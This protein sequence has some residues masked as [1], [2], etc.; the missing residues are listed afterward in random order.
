MFKT[1]LFLIK[2]GDK[3]GKGCLFWQKI[4]PERDQRV[5][6][7]HVDCALIS[8]LFCK[9][10]SSHFAAQSFFFSF[11]KKSNRDWGQ[12]QYT[13]VCLFS[14]QLFFFLFSFFFCKR[15]AVSEVLLLFPVFLFFYSRVLSS[16]FHFL[17]FSFYS[18]TIY[19]VFRL[20][21]RERV[22]FFLSFQFHFPIFWLHPRPT[23]THVA[24]HVHAASCSFYQFFFSFCSLTPLYKIFFTFFF[25]ILFG[26]HNFFPCM[27]F[28]FFFSSNRSSKF[29]LNCFFFIS[30]SCL[31]QL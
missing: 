20:H 24:A 9:L 5:A 15:S 26:L 19:R 17:V 14:Q 21:K 10:C 23:A 2:R 27:F 3:R 6:P 28:S 4:S 18:S 30:Y 1:Y 7:I 11:V 29:L 13:L 25:I 8:V 22:Q 16:Q 12:L 31:L